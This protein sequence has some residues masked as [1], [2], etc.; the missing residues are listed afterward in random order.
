[1]LS[2]ITLTLFIIRKNIELNIKTVDYL[3]NRPLCKNCNVI[4]VSLDTLSA[5]HLPC[6]GYSRNTAPNLCN[7][8]QNNIFFSNAYSNASW[9]L[10][11][12]VSLLT[13]L[14]DY[15]NGKYVNGNKL[16][17]TVQ[18]YP[19]ILKNL[20]YKTLF[21]IPFD[22]PS[23]PT[24]EVYFRLQDGLYDNNQ[25]DWAKSISLFK[26]SV[27]S[28]AKTFM[29]LHTYDVHAPYLIG[30]TSQIYDPPNKTFP[31]TT[32]D[33]N[34][35]FTYTP[36]FVEQVVNDVKKGIDSKWNWVQLR[37]S[38]EKYFPELLQAQ[39]DYEKEVAVLK[40]M[41]SAGLLDY[42]VTEYKYAI[43]TKN[44]YD[45]DTLRALYDQKINQLDSD[46]LE[47]LFK[48]INDPTYSKN[49]ILI[50]FSD[51]G[52]EFLEHGHMWHETVY[53]SNLKV[54]LI[55]Y[56]P[57]FTG[58]KI[59]TA[60]Q[61]T[62]VVPTLNTLLGIKSKVHYDGSN[63]VPM[64]LWNNK[65][66]K[67][68]VSDSFNLADKSIISWPWKLFLSK[69]K[70]GS[71]LPYALYNIEVDPTELDNQLFV[72]QKVMKSILKLP[73]LSDINIAILP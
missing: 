37:D 18:L 31:L 19:E 70:D 68:I 22:D 45:I 6:Y 11:S 34:Q 28:G 50:I 60:V 21:F 63:L 26:K 54:P 2:C 67:S 1:M 7:F 10:P 65:F 4:M 24:D 43:L 61:L 66:K 58:K 9:T 64:I 40:N 73:E 71:Y 20:G 38:A 47:V 33:F 51:H 13:G 35:P 69:Q 16:N 29:F 12:H 57:N 44:Q 30:N 27:D 23:F 36:K 53:N 41:E 56:I 59:D 39:P 62:D 32:N 42:Y 8:A 3:L 55:M 72:K 5:N 14:Y 25:Y 15:H 48:L 52:E 49:T 46:N 17:S